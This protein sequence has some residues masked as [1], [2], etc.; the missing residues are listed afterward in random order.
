[1]GD[2]KYTPDT[3]DV[4]ESYARA[5]ADA[6]YKRRGI[7]PEQYTEYHEEFDRWLAAHDREV[8]AKALREA[9]DF[10]PASVHPWLVTTADRIEAEK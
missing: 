10:L 9:A 8:R 2:V 5:E 6:E 3:T 4:R 7:H 1:M